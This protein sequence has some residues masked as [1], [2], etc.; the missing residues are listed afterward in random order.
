MVVVSTVATVPLIYH[1]DFVVDSHIEN[2]ETAMPPTAESHC[3]GQGRGQGRGGGRPRSENRA[4]VES[5]NLPQAPSFFARII[6]T[7]MLCAL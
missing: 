6:T 3:R 4:S 7:I 1:N 5:D 2:Q